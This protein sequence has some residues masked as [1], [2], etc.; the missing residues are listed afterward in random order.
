MSSPNGMRQRVPKDKARP[1]TPTTEVA[2]EKAADVIEKIKPYKPAQQ[3]SEWDYRVAIT[4]LTILGFVTRFW[5][6]TH[7][8]QVVFDEV[9][10]GKVWKPL[11]DAADAPQFLPAI[12]S[13][14]KLPCKADKV[15]SSL[16]TICNELTFSTST[17]HSENSSSPL[18]AGSL[19]TRVIFSSTTLAIRTSPTRFP[20]SPTAQCPPR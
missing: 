17:L 16:H 8:D 18:P 2:R 13:C 5:G 6:I 9:H 20:M 14:I 7:P 10:F 11:V 4:V 12:E 15:P 19:D 3:G 1:T